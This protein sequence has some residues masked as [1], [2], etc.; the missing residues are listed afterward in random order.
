MID[1]HVLSSLDKIAMKFLGL[2]FVAQSPDNINQQYVV[3]ASQVIAALQAAYRAGV[4]ERKCPTI[5]MKQEVTP[6]KTSQEPPPEVHYVLDP[7]VA[8][9]DYSFR[10][11]IFG[12]RDTVFI[13]EAGPGWGARYVTKHRMS[14]S[15]FD[16]IFDEHFARYA[17]SDAAYATFLRDLIIEV[18]EH[19]A[20]YR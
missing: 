3:T 10:A 8:L 13:Q 11:I 6:N 4:D 7:G 15:A 12:D 1:T 5:Q 9:T 16:S 20:G 14:R 18:E 17:E 2:N 19:A